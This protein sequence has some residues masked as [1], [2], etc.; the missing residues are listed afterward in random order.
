[1]PTND[2]LARLGEP[3]AT[4]EEEAQALLEE[5]YLEGRRR[6]EPGISKPATPELGLD[7]KARTTIDWIDENANRTMACTETS[8]LEELGRLFPRFEFEPDSRL[9][10]GGMGVVYLV[11][12]VALDWHVALKMIRREF[13][14]DRAF[15]ER[16]RREARAMAR[17]NHPCIARVLDFG[18][19]DDFFYL[20]MEFLPGGSLRER[21]RDEKGQPSPLN[22][23]DPDKALA[24]AAA[25]CDALQHAHAKEVVHRDVSPE[26]ILFDGDNHPKVADLG[27]ARVCGATHLTGSV[28]AMGK[29]DYMAPEQR[30]N[31]ATADHRADI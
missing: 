18:K 17:L 9:G 2:E 22:R 16:F 6:G 28:Q 31:A 19:A 20:E 15:I 24:L 1:M 8:E 25:I 12:H 29:L 30:Q 10:G 21:L 23:D 5:Q 4:P 3:P 14:D 13:S 11:R 26:N 27:L 7:P